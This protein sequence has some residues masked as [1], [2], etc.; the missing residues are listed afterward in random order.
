MEQY[1]P[2]RLI[3]QRLEKEFGVKNWGG[4]LELTPEKLTRLS[5]YDLEIVNLVSFCQS[6]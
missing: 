3:S 2:Y 4:F 6:A 5:P 1:P